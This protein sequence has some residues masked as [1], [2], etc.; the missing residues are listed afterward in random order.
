MLRHA[1]SSSSTCFFLYIS[2]ITPN[3]EP[4]FLC[5][6]LHEPSTRFLETHFKMAFCIILVW[7]NGGLVA[8]GN[9]MNIYTSSKQLWEGRSN[10]C[11]EKLYCLRHLILN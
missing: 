4:F 1:S 6:R 3:I 10:W 9:M 7:N 2:M 8:S 11:Q 5:V